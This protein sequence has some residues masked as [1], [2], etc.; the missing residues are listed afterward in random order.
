MNISEL[1]SHRMVSTHVETEKTG[2]HWLSGTNC[3]QG[4]RLKAFALDS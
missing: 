4:T 3:D 2:K 1:C